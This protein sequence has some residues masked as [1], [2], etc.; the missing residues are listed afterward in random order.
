MMMSNEEICRAYR[1]AKDRNQQIRIMAELNAVSPEVIVGILTE[2]GEIIGTPQSRGRGR[3]RKPE[4]EK[5]LQQYIGLAEQGFTVA[6]AA[7][8]LGVTRRAVQI[9]AQKHGIRFADSRCK[10]K[11]RPAST[12]REGGNEKENHP[13]STTPGEENQPGMQYQTKVS[14]PPDMVAVIQRLLAA[15]G[16]LLG[17]EVKVTACGAL[18]EQAVVLVEMEFR[19]L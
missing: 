12:S 1:T 3:P 13:Q 11:S 10:R 9:Y 16:Q 2:A 5:R 8:A 4:D 18:P 14:A 7:E 17:G 6:E 15:A 19:A